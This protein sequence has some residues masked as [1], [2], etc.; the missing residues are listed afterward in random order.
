MPILRL[1][2]ERGQIKRWGAV[3]HIIVSRISTRFI[4]Y[5]YVSSGKK[6]FSDVWA[7]H[8]CL[9]FFCLDTY[10]FTKM[11]QKCL[12]GV[13]DHPRPIRDQ[14]WTILDQNRI[15][16]ILRQFLIYLFRRFVSSKLVQNW[17]LIGR[18]WSQTPPRH[19]W[20]IFVKIVF[21]TK[22]STQT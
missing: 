19:F 7:F 1:C 6:W 9:P 16:T 18:G 22:T 13:W 2:H 12:G 15:T 20:S 17:S 10:F 5:F 4:F 21:S 11:V 8:V 3:R 14:F